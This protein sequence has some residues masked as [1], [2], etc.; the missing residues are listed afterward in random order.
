MDRQ[1]DTRPV[2]ERTYDDL[3]ID[4]G[5]DRD[6][7]AVELRELRNRHALLREA[8]AG[9]RA[10]EDGPAEARAALVRDAELAPA[11]EHYESEPPHA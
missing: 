11:G 10:G 1:V 4:V 9:V 5:R 7:L 2:R 8:L 6:A 3:V